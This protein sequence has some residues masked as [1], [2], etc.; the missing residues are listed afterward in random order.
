VVNAVVDALRPWGVDDVEMPA[1]PQ[2]VWRA[3]RDGESAQSSQD[4]PTG[5]P[6]MELEPGGRL[7]EGEIGIESAEE[8]L[9]GDVP[10]HRRTT[11]DETG[12]AQ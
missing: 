12:G 6:D 11:Q 8:H 3:I 9:A 10:E 2:R 1:T 5:V 4:L 7:A